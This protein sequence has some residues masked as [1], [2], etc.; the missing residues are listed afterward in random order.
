LSEVKCEAC[1]G[2]GVE[3]I[4]QP[5]KPG[6]RIYPAR[7]KVCGGKGRVAIHNPDKK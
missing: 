4:E 3:L 7:C 6:T 1:D 5:S 2:T